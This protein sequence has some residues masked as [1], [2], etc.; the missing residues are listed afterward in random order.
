MEEHGYYVEGLRSYAFSGTVE[1][2][3]AKEFIAQLRKEPLRE[4]GG[5]VVTVVRDYG[6]SVELDLAQGTSAPITLPQ[7][8]V[9]QWLTDQGSKVTI[10]PSGTE[11]KMKLYLGV[12]AGSLADARERLKVLEGAF[13]ALVQRGLKKA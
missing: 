1:A 9:I 11:P 6:R 4:I 8:D 5:E 12:R 10:R 2:Q 3:L 13:D 7:E